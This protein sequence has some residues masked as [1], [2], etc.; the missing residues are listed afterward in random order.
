MAIR[1]LGGIVVA[2]LLWGIVGVSTESSAAAL[3]R[4]LEA[5]VHD[6]PHPAAAQLLDNAVVGHNIGNYL[7][8]PSAEIFHQ[9]DL[10]INLVYASEENPLAI[11]RHGEPSP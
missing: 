6:T 3:R 5:Y 7:A 4:R 11:G 8:T 1:Y 10:A 2:T 9:H